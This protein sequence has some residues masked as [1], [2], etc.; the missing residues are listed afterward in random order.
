[1]PEINLKVKIKGGVK[2]PLEVWVESLAEKV[3]VIRFANGN[4]ISDR[5]MI[6][7]LTGYLTRKLNKLQEPLSTPATFREKVIKKMPLKMEFKK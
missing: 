5:D 2:T 3:R 1:M 4:Q 6:D 7:W